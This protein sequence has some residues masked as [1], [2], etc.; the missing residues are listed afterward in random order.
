MHPTERNRHISS[1][2]LA[3]LGMQD[4]AYIKQVVVDEVTGYSVHAADGTQ[5]ALMTNRD[6]AF[7]AVRQH[8]MEPVSVH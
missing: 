8:D 6:I 2:E 5:I 4:M 3:A 1:H 7:A